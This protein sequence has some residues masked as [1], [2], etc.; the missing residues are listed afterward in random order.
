MNTIISLIATPLSVLE[1]L[2]D[3]FEDCIV[4]FSIVAIPTILAMG[5]AAGML[6]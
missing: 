3:C 5:F 6:F 1:D 4:K 2:I